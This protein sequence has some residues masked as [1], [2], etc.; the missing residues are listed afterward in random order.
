MCRSFGHH[1]FISE[2]L[3][4]RPQLEEL[5]KGGQLGLSSKNSAAEAYETQTKTE[6]SK[7]KSAA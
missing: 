1:E 7:K 3:Q 2:E 5:Q 4:K 6:S